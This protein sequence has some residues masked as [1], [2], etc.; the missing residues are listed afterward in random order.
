MY[1]EN[2]DYWES[3]DND[4]DY[5]EALDQPSTHITDIYS[6]DIA[7]AEIVKQEPDENKILY[8]LATQCML[9]ADIDCGD[10]IGYFLDLL[11]SFVNQNG[12]TFRV[13]KTKNGMRYIQ[14]DA[15]YF[16]VTK[17][18]IKILTALESDEKYIK[19]C[20]AGNRF[21]AR[22]TPKISPNKVE[23]YYNEINTG[24]SP[25][26]AVCKLIKTVGNQPRSEMLYHAIALHD[27]ITQA[28][29]ERDDLI[30]M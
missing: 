24:Y 20:K 14:T 29:S 7:V 23:D 26:I 19:M 16:G 25:K 8:C 6:G 30:L 4:Y 10:D 12:G 11:E 5:D 28:D 9:I 13:Y 1:D 15:A 17:Q 18:A 22:V 27:L 3:F 2:Y 21:M